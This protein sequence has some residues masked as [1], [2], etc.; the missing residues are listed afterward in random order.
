M[1]NA[2]NRLRF[3][4]LLLVLGGVACNT[5][6]EGNAIATND[7]KLYKSDV[8]PVLIRDCG[9]HACHGAPERFFRVWG[10]GRARMDPAT[11]SFALLT[12]SENE[13]NYSVA[14]SMIDTKNPE[15]SLLLRKPLAVEA[16]GS[17]HLGVDKYGRNVYRTVNDPGYV[18]I[19]SWVMSMATTQA[20]PQQM[21]M[22]PPMP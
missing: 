3:V 19:K 17:G 12:A 9:F 16:G 1:S 2:C 7:F 22:P 13:T 14:L 11:R 15:R 8:Y 5:A 6:S 18:A 21:M 10:P 20:P 4:V